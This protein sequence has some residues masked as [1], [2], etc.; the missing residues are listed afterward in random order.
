MNPSKHQ[1]R[2]RDIPASRGQLDL[3]EEQMLAELKAALQERFREKL[4]RIVLFGSRARPDSIGARGDAMPNSDID[5]AVIVKSLDRKLKREILDIVADLELK[6]LTPISM[7][8]FSTQEFD[9]LLKRERRIALDI[10]RE[11]IAL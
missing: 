9:H 6:H 5:V 7:L 11:G 10:A 3:K 2:A 8:V 1:P 4:Q